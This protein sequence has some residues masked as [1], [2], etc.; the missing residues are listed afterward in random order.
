MPTRALEKLHSCSLI[1]VAE[2]KLIS[3][4]VELSV[5][6]PRTQTRAPARTGRKPKGRRKS[7]LVRLP[8]EVYDLLEKAVPGGRQNDFIVAAVADKLGVFGYRQDFQEVL[9]IEEI[10]A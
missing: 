2:S 8:E 1:G 4:T 9:P 10:A 3:E 6:E 7:R 5:M